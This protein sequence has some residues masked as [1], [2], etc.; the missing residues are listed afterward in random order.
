MP[1]SNLYAGT[2]RC[3]A[4]VPAGLGYCQRGPRRWIILCE[5]CVDVGLA[6]LPSPLE[7]DKAIDPAGAP[8]T[9]L[10]LRDLD[11]AA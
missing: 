2:C 3:G 9:L 5:R 7:I 10:G 6:A 4:E 8:D 11:D 1:C